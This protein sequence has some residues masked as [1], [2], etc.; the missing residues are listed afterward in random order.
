MGAAF[1]LRILLVLHHELD[2]AT[3]APGATLALRD[4][5]RAAGHHVSTFSFDDLPADMPA[6][7]REALFPELFALALTRRLRRE[8]FDVVDAATGDAWLWAR[9]RH[10]LRWPGLL[11]C[12]SHGLEHTFWAEEVREASRQGRRLTLRSRLYHGRLRLRESALSL[13]GSDLCL[14]LN[15][16]DRDVAVGRLGV[17]P[18]RAVLIPNGIPAALLGRA[19]P[20]RADEPLRLAHIG[21]YADRK[22]AR[23]LAKAVG[24]FLQRHPGA[25]MTYVGARVPRLRLLADHPVSVRDSIDVVETFDRAQLPRLL[26]GHHVLVSASLAEG[27]SLALVEGMACGL[28]PVVTDL[29]GSREVVAQDVEGVLVPPRAPAALLAALESLAG[30]RARL[31]RLREAA[32]AKAQAYGWS[33]VAAATLALYAAWLRRPRVRDTPS[34]AASSSSGGMAR[35]AQAASR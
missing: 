35:S 31:L 33:D 5:F 13:R 21:S 11:V 14:L 20:E 7:A 19:R 27:F 23:D 29:P 17:Q 2:A 26:A 10:A 12:R 4:E 3:G 28:V 6:P 1:P 15:G 16:A 8:R 34:R 22:G 18:E 30:D 25:R 9:M 24:E 32:H